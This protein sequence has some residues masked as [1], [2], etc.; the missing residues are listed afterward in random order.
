MFGY[1]SVKSG[2]FRQTGSSTES[3][4]RTGDQI[5]ENV[6]SGLLQL[7]FWV[8]RLE[9][10][11]RVVDLHLPVDAPLAGIY[12]VRLGGRFRAEFIFAT[13]TTP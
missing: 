7:N 12:I 13:D 3:C 4:G 10:G 5:Y 1:Y 11:P 6:S 8:D 9:L 2:E